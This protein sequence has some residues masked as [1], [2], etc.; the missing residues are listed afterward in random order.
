MTEPG[1]T[2]QQNGNGA[3]PVANRSVVQGMLRHVLRHARNPST[4]LLLRAVPEW[5]ENEA[6]NADLG[7]SK[8]P[9]I[10]KPCRTV[11]GILDALATERAD[12]TYLVVL[13]SCEGDKVA[14]SIL[15][16]AI[17]RQVWAIDRWDLVQDAFGTPRLD[18]LLTDGN[19]TWLPEALLDAQPVSGWRKINSPILTLDT[20][21]S[22]LVAARLG[23]QPDGDEIVVDAAALLLWTTDPPAV[24][25]FHR[26]SRDEER[27]GI[28]GW[29]LGTVPGVADAIFAI[30]PP[31]RI[32]EAVPLG[33]AI[34][35]LYRSDQPS[36]ERVRAEERYFAGKAPGL[37][38]MRAFGE[39]AES[40]ITRWTSNGSASQA[41]ANDMR[42]RA[43]IILRELQADDFASQ[44]AVLDAG[45]DARFRALAQALGDRSVPGAQK[46]L[47]EILQ[48]K[49]ARARSGET[50]AA[51]AAAR[52]LRWL[53]APEDKP[54][55]LAD[56]ATLMVRSWSWAD[57]ALRAIERPVASRVPELTAAYSSLSA[58]ARRRRARLDETFARKLATW[59]QASSDPRDL[60][61]VEN[62]LDR[63]A[64]PLAEHR[65]PLLVVLDGMSASVAAQIVGQ[66][67]IRNGWIEVGRREDGREPA[68]ATVPSVTSISRTSLLC[69]AL[70]S[71]GQAEERNGFAA[72]WGRR[73]ARLFHKGDL[74]PEPGDALAGPLREAIADT[75]CVVGV[76]LNTIDDT[77]DK[78][79][80]G[81]AGWLDTEVR[82]LVPLLDAARRA[83]RPVILTADHG[84]V[85][86]RGAPV[87][88]AHSDK[89]RYRTGGEAGPG[90]ITVGGPRVIVGNGTVVAAVDEGI[91]YTPR[92]A[93]YH[94]GASAA[95]V[96]VPVIVLLPSA[97]QK[98]SGWHEYEP[99]GHAPLW[100]DATWVPV[101]APSAGA[102]AKPA[103]RRKE[104]PP[105][106]MEPLFGEAS[107]GARVIA[108]SRLAEQRALA[109]RA[110]ADEQVAR[111]IDALAASGGRLTVAEVAAVTGEPAVRMIG[112]MAQV[113][114]LLN[115]EGYRVIAITDGNKTVVLNRSLLSEQFLGG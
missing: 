15:A 84:H 34:S 28:T 65:L 69:G 111:L 9:V 60:L 64:R 26:I 66:P 58:A 2:G 106:G 79:K 41:D 43:E 37:E 38:A 48:H 50:A 87:S 59:T 104:S 61:L 31:D 17:G 52:V 62:L 101:T 105:A 10:V 45:L 29:V 11:L 33:L 83:G 74:A 92:K 16:R 77:L 100:W 35:P 20:A 13:T 73:A 46:A 80:P 55:T 56:A 71:G 54:G 103:P 112:Y 47:D 107:L 78:G 63:V 36:V 97:S 109:R 19:Y 25:S 91:H 113:T 18:R 72:F 76:V 89:S 32:T 102:P 57:R 51:E 94:G 4:V 96:V 88:D 85:L 98:P 44:S 67:S 1:V 70:R 68:L 53:A 95:E 30:T 23:Q 90:E 82:Y 5:R 114:R 6:F 110:P 8:V 49:R 21:M 93:G 99:G 86:D 7:D 39:A 42:A 40:L 3:P 27:R 108:S 115:V 24:A 14:D 75:D 22:R 12:G 81:D